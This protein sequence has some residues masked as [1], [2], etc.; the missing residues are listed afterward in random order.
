M[1]DIIYNPYITGMTI[2]TYIHTQIHKLTHTHTHTVPS[3]YYSDFFFKTVTENTS[4]RINDI[5]NP[6][7]TGITIKIASFSIYI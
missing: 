5:Y 1:S 4:I 6:Y 7:R 2:N 3:T